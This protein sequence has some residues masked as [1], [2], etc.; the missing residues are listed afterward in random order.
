MRTSLIITTV[1]FPSSIVNL[2]GAM[3][4]SGH[5]IRTLSGVYHKGKKKVQK[6][7]GKTTYKGSITFNLFL[8]EKDDSD[9]QLLSFKSKCLSNQITMFA[10][11]EAD[12][13]FDNITSYPK[14]LSL[15]VAVKPELAEA[16]GRLI[17]GESNIVCISG[18]YDYTGEVSA[19]IVIQNN[20]KATS[21]SRAKETLI[22][23]I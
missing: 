16:L 12:K 22:V 2:F 21:A 7:L 1:N 17:E 6:K 15:E 13:R 11:H 9:K 10:I 23:H 4:D 5:H 19:V 20:K 14:F 18:T 8:S 3:Q